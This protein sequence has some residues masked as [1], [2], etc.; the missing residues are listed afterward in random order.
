MWFQS[1]RSSA[2]SAATG[3]WGFASAIP[4]WNAP[5]I[6]VSALLEKQ[7]CGHSCTP[8]AMKHTQNVITGV[9][10]EPGVVVVFLLA[11]SLTFYFKLT[12]EMLSFFSF[13]VQLSQASPPWASTRRAAPS[14]PAATT[15]RLVSFWE[16]P[17]RSKWTAAPQT[18]ATPSQSAGPRPPR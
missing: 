11:V 13:A 15:P 7:V 8:F 2:T 18:T 5:P 14:Q 4:E 1:T 3:C 16:S 6:P 17:I 10:P 12:G 9:R